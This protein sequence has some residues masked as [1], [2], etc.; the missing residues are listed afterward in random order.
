MKKFGLFIFCF[1][2][3]STMSLSAQGTLETL[4]AQKAEKVAMMGEAQ[5][6]VD[7]LKSE[8]DALQVDIDKLSGWITGYSGIVGFD[9]NKSNNWA[10]NPNPNSSSSALNIGLTGFANKITTKTFWNNKLLLTK[11]WQDVNTVEGAEGLGLFDQSTVDI[12]NLSS[13]YGYK[14]NNWIAASALGELNTSL[15]NFLSPGTLDFGV[16][17]TL[18]PMDNLVI[19]IHPFNYHVAFSGIDNLD[20]QGSLGAKLRADYGKEFMINGRKLVWSS[21]FTTFIPYKNK[22]TLVPGTDY[23]AGLSEYT[24]LNTLG[25]EVW[26]G[27]GVGISAGLRNA[28]FE[29]AKTQSFYSLGLSYNL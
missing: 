17:A 3:L 7:A 11:S 23:E 26:K 14:L 12:L 9:L 13:L 28:E 25:F 18:T 22:K 6:K 29:S 1:F 27:I 5:A 16:G 19:V 21:T 24:W 4:I 10:S 20:S 15:W 8:I 2:I